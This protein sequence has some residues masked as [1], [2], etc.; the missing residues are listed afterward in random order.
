MAYGWYLE[1]E[2]DSGFV[3]TEDEADHSPYDAGRNTFHAILNGRPTEGHGP[4]V[5][6]SLI[7]D[8]LRYDI[9]WTTLPEGARPVYYRQMQ[10]GFTVE[11]GWQ[12]AV[13]T[14]HSFGWQATV[15]GESVREVHEIAG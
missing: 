6:F 5:R 8:G 13:C 1:A 3:L 12:P 15:D 11:G 14:S 2:Y 10:R 7:G 9:D 4:L